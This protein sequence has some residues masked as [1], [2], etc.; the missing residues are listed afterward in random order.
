MKNSVTK[1]GETQNLERNFTV[2]YSH[3]FSE[4][5]KV[6]VNKNYNLSSN[7]IKIK[8]K[9]KIQNIKNKFKI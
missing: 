6:K 8:Y 9:F 1:T 7:K 3:P 2:V 4:N 5:F